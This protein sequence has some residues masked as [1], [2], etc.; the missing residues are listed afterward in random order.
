MY[1]NSAFCLCS[2]Q[3]G[4]VSLLLL[5]QNYLNKALNLL[6]KL[7]SNSTVLPSFIPE[8]QLYLK[9]SYFLII[10]NDLIICVNS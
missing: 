9:T 6:N 8:T 2:N 1:V 3:I 10:V 5:S 7:L 4:Q